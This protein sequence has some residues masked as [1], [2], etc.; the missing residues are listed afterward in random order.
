MIKDIKD[1]TL[2][3]HKTFAW[4]ILAHYF[5]LI[6]KKL[7]KVFWTNVFKKNNAL[8]GVGVYNFLMR[9]LLKMKFSHNQLQSMFNQ[10]I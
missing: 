5:V 3:I 7:R 6:I 4:N 10:K 1:Q 8:V 9:W 2:N